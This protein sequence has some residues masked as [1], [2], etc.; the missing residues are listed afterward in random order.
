MSDT[1]SPTL[2]PL[3]TWRSAVSSPHGPKDA[4][5][6]HVLLALSLYMNERGGSCFPS[7]V[8]LA[9]DTGLNERTVRDHLSLA[10]QDGWITRKR[11]GYGD[12]R[13]WRYEYESA[14]PS[15]IRD[16]RKEIPVVGVGLPESDETTT[17]ISPHDYRK[18][19]PTNSS[20]NTPSN[21]P[22]GE[23]RARVD[24]GWV[25]STTSPSSE[26]GPATLI[27]EE[28]T[29]RRLALYW[30][31]IIEKRV[32]TSPARLD[33]WRGTV[34]TWWATTQPGHIGTPYNLGNIRRMLDAFDEGAPPA[35]RAEPGASTPP[36]RPKDALTIDEMMAIQEKDPTATFEPHPAGFLTFRRTNTGASA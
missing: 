4:T 25:K 28:V 18:E 19:V 23:A 15:H 26:A 20:G 27:Y 13:F 32:G 22:E 3:F 35:T 5:T 9:A 31:D 10:V 17:G 33:W 36:Q 24:D 34:M 14:V 16:I 12:R 1:P 7:I 11:H 29:R 30:R 21:S 6:K 2:A 8:T